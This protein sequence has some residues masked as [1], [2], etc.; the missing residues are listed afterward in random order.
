MLKRAAKTSGLHASFKRPQKL[1]RNMKN[2]PHSVS[3]ETQSPPPTREA[4][5]YRG[6]GAVGQRSFLRTMGIAGASL[7]L[8]LTLLVASSAMAHDAFLKF[9]GGIGVMPVSSVGPTGAPV[10]NVVRGIQPAGQ[11]WIIRALRAEVKVDGRIHVDGR[12]LLLAGGNAI[13]TTGGASVFATLICGPLPNGPFTVHST[14]AVALEADGD[15][16]IDDILSPA[17]TNGCD[18]PVLLI[19]N[20]GG[21]GVWFAAGIPLVF[22]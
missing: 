1:D 19:R 10:A 8:V 11:P 15:F 20:T 2:S 16:T 18:N 7:A 3:S 21:V 5:D 6:T 14:K 12:S 9:N 22:E 4:I 17:P 13:G